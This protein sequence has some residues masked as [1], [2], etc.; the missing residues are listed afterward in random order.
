MTQRL[1]LK[2]E[3]LL[4]RSFS[5]KDAPEV[6][7]LAGDRDIAANV[8]DIP[9][10]YEDGLAEEW[11]S[12]HK[13]R[14]ERGEIILAIALHDTNRLIGTIGLLIDRKDE[15]AELGFWIGKPYWG[16]GYCT[17]AATAL[18]RY[19]FDKQ[20]LNRIHA[21]HLS[22]NPASGRVLQKI[23]MSHEGCLRQAIKKWG[24]FEDVEVYSILRSEYY[25]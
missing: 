22:R 8:R 19:G 18:I 25:K 20:E 21:F 2:T 14:L 13:E 15:N 9:H 12:T 1:S 6:Q 24:T 16:K 23:G 4:L 3:R 10:P 17:E 7:R 11:I 5:I